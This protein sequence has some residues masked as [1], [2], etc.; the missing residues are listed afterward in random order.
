[1]C[2]CRA[3]A[4]PRGRPPPGLILVRTQNTA[5][6]QSSRYNERRSITTESRTEAQKEARRK[7]LKEARRKSRDRDCLKAREE[8]LERL[9]QQERCGK[10]RSAAA[11]EAPWSAFSVGH[12]ITVAKDLAGV[13][14][15]RGS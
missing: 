10:V 13:N 14:Q 12:G 8:A 15:E 1:M 11:P 9:R 6:L 2:P 3:V 4:A 7:G 5:A